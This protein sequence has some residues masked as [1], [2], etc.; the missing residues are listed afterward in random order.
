M[1]VTGGIFYFFCQEFV[2]SLFCQFLLVLIFSSFVC[3]VERHPFDVI[4]FGY[5][6]TFGVFVPFKGTN[7]CQCSSPQ[8]R[9]CQLLLNRFRPDED[10]KVAGL[11]NAKHEKND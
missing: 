5:S 10:R 1:T 9:R 6:A 2:S 7:P 11:V 8:F 4:R 3:A